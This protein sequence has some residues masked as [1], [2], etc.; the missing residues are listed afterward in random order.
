M[1]HPARQDIHVL[2]YLSSLI[3]VSEGKVIYVG[4]PGVRSCPL[5]RRFYRE[6]RNAPADPEE[7][8]KAIKRIIESKIREYGFFTP[9][10]DLSVTEVQVPYG[11]SEILMFALRR[12]AID[13]AVVVC[14]GAGTVVVDTPQTV[15]GIGA[16]MHTLI[17][18]SPIEETMERLASRGCH[19]VSRHAAIEPCRGVH[20]AAELGY[21]TIAV[22]VSGQAAARLGRLRDIERRY[23]V[24]VISLVVC[25]TGIDGEKRGEIRRHAD[26][27]WSCQSAEIREEIGPAA[28]R[29]LSKGMP[30]FVLSE[31][32]MGFATGYKH[33]ERA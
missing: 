30:V 17:M 28:R 32:G 26:L 4:D 8:K 14:D 3:S 27:V 2:R 19:V 12:K 33:E 1:D 5:A 16:R 25:T 21:K 20:R 23:G 6:L 29:Q 24:K 15:Q 18:T 7:T 9:R 31:A 22:T 13:A 11:A 10:R